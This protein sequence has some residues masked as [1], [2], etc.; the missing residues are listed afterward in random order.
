MEERIGIGELAERTGLSESALRMWEHRHG[1]PVPVRGSATAHRRYSSHDVELVTQVRDAKAAGLPL[2][3]AI[4][5]V[6]NRQRRG[7]TESVFGALLDEFPG[8]MSFRVP[9]PAAVDL[10]RALEDE[11]LARATRPVV[12]GS[13]QLGERFAASSRRW[14]ELA[15]TASWCAVAA[16]FSQGGHPYPESKVA[17]CDLPEDSPMRRE[18]TVAWWDGVGGSILNGWEVPVERG[19][20]AL[21]EL[22]VSTRLDVVAA[23]ARVLVG[24]MRAQ[25]VRIPS[26]VIQGLE[27]P[28]VASPD[29]SISDRI[30]ARAAS[31][32]GKKR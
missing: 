4:A 26:T 29:S 32:L 11:C 10:S 3:V 28:F 22:V 13:F 7:S 14:S 1:F 18:W 19:G 2:G 30:L 15:R 31:R 21:Y 6:V 12:L 27:Q 24:V 5:N 16:D 9:R 20:T 25:G 17:W 8:L 23:A